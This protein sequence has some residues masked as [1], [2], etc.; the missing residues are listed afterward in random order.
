MFFLDR[1]SRRQRHA[2]PGPR[3]VQ[4]RHRHASPGSSAIDVVYDDGV[5]RG[6]FR[7]SSHMNTL[8]AGR[9]L[10]STAE[11]FNKNASPL[12]IRKILPPENFLGIDRSVRG[13][14]K[15]F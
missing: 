2:L 5:R 14:S 13:S 15:P 9:A 10:P 7:G 11:R 8:S 12:I 1:K 6:C 3:L 4:L